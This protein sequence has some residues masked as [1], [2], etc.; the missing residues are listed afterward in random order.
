MKGGTW[1]TREPS[2]SLGEMRKE[3]CSGAEVPLGEGE[4]V[5]GISRGPLPGGMDGWSGSWGSLEQVRRGG[6]GPFVWAAQMQ[7]PLGLFGLI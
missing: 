5:L 7:R 3:R 1:E 2:K 4:A 6:S